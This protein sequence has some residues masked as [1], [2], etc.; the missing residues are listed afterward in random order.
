MRSPADSGVPDAAWR[1]A[2]ASGARNEN[3]LPGRREI[4]CVG[5]MRAH[6]E[7]TEGTWTVDGANAGAVRLP[8]GRWRV[9]LPPRE[10]TWVALLGHI[11]VDVDAVVP[12]DPRPRE[13]ELV[14]TTDP[15]LDPAGC[16]PGRR[17]A[18]HG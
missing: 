3:G 4:A 10:N 18:G 6:P 12:S 14:V 15:A 1:I 5:A 7:T 16:S 13:R 2:L 17:R 8:D 11:R 9:Q